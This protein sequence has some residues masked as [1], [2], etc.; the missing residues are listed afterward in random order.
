MTEDEM[1]EQDAIDTRI[2][3]EE[4]ELRNAEHDAW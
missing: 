1:K 2:A 4:G 3:I